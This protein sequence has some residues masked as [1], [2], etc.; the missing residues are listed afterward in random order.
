MQ[1]TAPTFGRL[2]AMVIFALSCFG[3]LL[4]LWL[5]FGGT[6]PLKPK[7]YRFQVAFP[8]AT[9]L[10]P[11]ADVRIAG[12]TVGK[13]RD[14]KR[15]PRSNRTLATIEVQRKYAPI[16]ADT[17]A[18]LR[19]KTL[20]GE[21]YIELSPG[22]PNAPKLKEGARLASSRVQGTVEFD[23]I[24]NTFDA[25]T[26]RAFRVWQQ[27]MGEA[28]GSTG[29]R[30]N[31]AVGQ[32]P[33]FLDRGTDLLQ[34]LDTDRAA[35]KRL[36]KNT[37]VVFG[38]LTQREQQ[39]H[40]LIVNTHDVFDTTARHE[41]NLAET[42]RILPTFLDESRATFRRTQRFAAHA[43]PVVQLLRDPTRK[44]GPT[45]ADLHALA[46]DLT[47]TFLGVKRLIPV[48]KTGMPALTDT[49]RGLRPF[50]SSMGPFLAELNP[51]FDQME[52]NQYLFTDFWSGGGAGLT[53]TLHTSQTTGVGHYLRSFGP[54]GIE[55]AAIYRQRLPNNRG[56]SY[57]QG[58]I[59]A[60]PDVT[61]NLIAPSWDCNNTGFGQGPPRGVDPNDASNDSKNPTEKHPG[62]WVAPPISFQGKLT[63]YPRVERDDYSKAP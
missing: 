38:A 51:V 12:V 45:V 24:L 60:G 22:S 3:L 47:R 43:R 18:I 56:D 7:G 59:E 23:E 48:S 42:F 1:K 35:L 49:L 55:G 25:P 44:L 4:F 6:V 16:P 13:V 29:R 8:E 20:L 58:T 2:A 52:Q 46:P 40:N 15:D 50:F 28:V 54:N 57:I 5:S 32:L 63:K 26:R 61:H 39:L 17:R 62:C 53:D 21:T 19:Q 27:Q 37:G 33:V 31:D 36:V 30:L 41:R 10:G 9:Q 14:K 34:V 11:E